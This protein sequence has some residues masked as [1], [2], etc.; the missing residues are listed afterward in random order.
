MT[1]ATMSPAAIVA[2][3]DPVIRQYAAQGER[4]RRLAPAVIDAM[5][6]AGVFRAW[7]PRALGGLEMDP[8]SAMGLFE[9]LAQ[10]DAAAG[11]V[12]SNSVNTT[13][14][15]QAFPEEG[16]RE[17]F[18]D[19]RALIAVAAFPPGAATPVDGGYRVSGQWI[20]AS[21]CHYATT[22]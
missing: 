22:I 14:T 10:A 7:V 19:P 9:G 18:A 8:V 11:W 5:L 15:F 4:D 13:V 2:Q 20:S 17:V 3:V 1:T 16:A 6:D 12:A 21:G